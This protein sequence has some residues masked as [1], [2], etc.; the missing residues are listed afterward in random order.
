MTLKTIRE[1]RTKVA[2]SVRGR[3]GC[4]AKQEK[5]LDITPPAIYFKL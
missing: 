1:L 3:C 5:S 2:A 4:P